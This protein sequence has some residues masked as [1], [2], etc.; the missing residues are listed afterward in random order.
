MI[1]LSAISKNV[2]FKDTVELTF[3]ALDTNGDGRIDANE[4][5]KV[6]KRVFLNI[7]DEVIENLFKKVDINQD[8][9]ISFGKLIYQCNY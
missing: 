8:G 1:G 2:S 3:K 6:M 4:M 7:E 5:E 9:T